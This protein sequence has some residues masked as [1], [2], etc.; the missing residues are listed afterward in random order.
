M[1]EHP[2]ILTRKTDST[3]VAT[4]SRNIKSEINLGEVQKRQIIGSGP[5]EPTPSPWFS[6]L[7]LP[8]DNKMDKP[9]YLLTFPLTT[10]SSFTFF[11]TIR[12]ECISLRR[13]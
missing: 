7:P 3:N 9:G 11:V 13:L 4:G 2:T 8:K 10:S 1:D 6:F 5:T 12:K